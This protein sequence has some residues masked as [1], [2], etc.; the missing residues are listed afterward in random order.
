[1]ALAG[2]LDEPSKVTYKTAE[3]LEDDPLAH[4]E[5]WFT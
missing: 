2:V 1:M 5:G 4:V 3:T